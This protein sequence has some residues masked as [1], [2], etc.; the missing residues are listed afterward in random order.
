MG[1]RQVRWA[2][3]RR[4][5][6]SDGRYVRKIQIHLCFG[7]DVYVETKFAKIK[8]SITGLQFKTFLIIIAYKFP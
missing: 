1:L 2:Y 7:S 4:E 8:F 6:E 5:R 3:G